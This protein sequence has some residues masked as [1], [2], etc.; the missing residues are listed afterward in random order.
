M[1]YAFQEIILGFQKFWADYNCILLQPYDMEM[2]AGT[3]H[4]AT[5][6]E[7][8]GPKNWNCVFVQPCRRP[9]DGRYG[10]NPNRLQ[11][12][13]Q[14]QVIL[15]PSPADVQNLVLESFDFV[16]LDVGKH[17][18]RFVEDDWE[19][20]SLGASGMGWE[21]WCD[22][23]EIL[24]FTYFQQVGGIPCHPVPAELTYGLERIAMCIQE[25]NTIFELAWNTPKSAYSKTYGDICKQAENEFSIWYFEKAPIDDLFEEFEKVLGYGKNLLSE[26]LILP[27]YEMCIRANHIF[28]MLDARRAV[29]IA[30]R[31]FYIQKI[32]SLASECCK[33]W[34]ECRAL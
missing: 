32:R 34:I 20:P 31:A 17:D 9:T 7:A 23:M 5:S 19:N 10:E 8:L 11:K 30:Q 12:Y 26:D 6:L 14:L 13:F 4:P 28:N 24:Q 15:K 25:K 2:G 18:I 3:S 29:S 33:K 16:G 1:T 21:V 22:G 27:S